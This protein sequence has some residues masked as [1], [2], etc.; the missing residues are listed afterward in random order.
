MGLKCK[1][2]EFKNDIEPELQGGFEG[3][4]KS[5]YP[6]FDTDEPHIFDIW[7]FRKAAKLIEQEVIYQKDIYESELV[8]ELNPRQLLQVDKTVNRS[9]EEDVKLELFTEMDN[10][11]FPLH[12]IDFETSVVAIPFH[13]NRSPYEQ[14]AFQFSCHT[15]HENGHIEHYEWIETEKGKFPN[16]DFVK[17]LKKVLDKDHGTIL[18][19]ASHENTVLRQIQSQMNG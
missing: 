17:N 14:I 1:H 15:Y 16:F 7:N 19:Y 9:T 12:F 4:W 13:K 3:C 5:V 8:N 2:C 18:R 10:W 6:D 11:Q